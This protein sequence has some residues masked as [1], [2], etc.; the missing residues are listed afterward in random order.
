MEKFSISEVIEQA[1]QTERLGQQYYTEMA[2]RF[3]ANEQLK[4]LFESLAAKEVQHERTFADLKSKVRE[5]E[6]EGWEEAAMYLRA[7]VESAFFLGG[8]KS[9]S[10]MKDVQSPVDAVQ[11]AIGFE[12]E[13]LLYYL[14]L[15]N[16]VTDKDVLETIIDEERSHIISLVRMKQEMS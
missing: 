9:L 14:E 15:K 7:I 2:A 1:V 5:P 3:N 10:S 12:K 8:G 13:S 4:K 11:Y 6:G 16:S